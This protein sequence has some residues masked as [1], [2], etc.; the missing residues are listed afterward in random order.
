VIHRERSFAEEEE[1][2]GEWKPEGEEEDADAWDGTTKG[3]WD[4]GKL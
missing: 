2:G 1:E 3:I 4:S